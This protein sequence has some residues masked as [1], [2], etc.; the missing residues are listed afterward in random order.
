MFLTGT[1]ELPS[2]AES[3]AAQ[4]AVSRAKLARRFTQLARPAAMAYLTE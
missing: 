1:Y 2:Q 3:V 4:V